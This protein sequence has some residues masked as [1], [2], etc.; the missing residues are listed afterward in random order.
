[1]YYTGTTVNRAFSMR[2]C[3]ENVPLLKHFIASIVKDLALK[4]LVVHTSLYKIK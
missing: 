3:G 4:V 1:M 2:K